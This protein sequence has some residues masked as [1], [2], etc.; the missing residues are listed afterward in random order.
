MRHLRRME[1]NKGERP[2]KR[3]ILILSIIAILGFA[4]G[5]FFYVSGTA[6]VLAQCQSSLD[7]QTA[8]QACLQQNAAAGASSLLIG[9]LLFVVGGL[10]GLIGWILGL[11]K[12]AQIG[13]W[14]WFVAVLLL[15]PLGSLIYG[16]AGPTER[17]GVAAMPVGTPYQ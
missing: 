2:V 1:A 9:I 3:A 7:D 15:S 8:L 17:A 16:I 4:G 10:C 5:I 11:V 13:R 6:A 12:T 14:G